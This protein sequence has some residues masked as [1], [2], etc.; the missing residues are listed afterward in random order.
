LTYLLELFAFTIL[1]EI[2]VSF[3][4]ESAERRGKRKAE[5]ISPTR[6]SHSLSTSTDNDR[7]RRDTTNLSELSP[8]N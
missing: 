6:D 1:S 7:K 3:V 8:E 5:A 4:M 2:I